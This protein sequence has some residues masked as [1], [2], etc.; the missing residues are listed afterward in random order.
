MEQPLEKITFTTAQQAL[1]GQLC[2]EW[3]RRATQL[4]SDAKACSDAAEKR[5][6]ENRAHVYQRDAL[7]L[8]TAFTTGDLP[9]GLGFQVRAIRD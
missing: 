4:F 1:L 8:R 5:R 9:K 3:C 6:L 2:D 7:D